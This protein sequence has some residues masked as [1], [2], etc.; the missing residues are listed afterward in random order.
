MNA[1]SAAAAPAPSLAGPDV[2]LLLKRSLDRI[3]DVPDYRER[4]SE[5]LAL[6]DHVRPQVADAAVGQVLDMA[7]IGVDH[8]STV[9]NALQVGRL[10]E[11]AI[12]S[13]QFGTF[14]QAAALTRDIIDVLRYD[15]KEHTARSLIDR[16]AARCDDPTAQRA[17]DLCACIASLCSWN[18][19]EGASKAALHTLASV[20]DGFDGSAQQTVELGIQL[21]RDVT[22]GSFD[23]SDLRPV[24]LSLCTGTDA[25]R[26]AAY[27]FLG[28]LIEPMDGESA[29]LFLRTE[30]D[31]VP[32]AL[33]SGDERETL[34]LAKTAVDVL[35]DSKRLPKDSGLLLESIGKVFEKRSHKSAFALARSLHDALCKDSDANNPD[36]SGLLSVALE[37]ANSN[38]SASSDREVL[39]AAGNLLRGMGS[40]WSGYEE[41][42]LGWLQASLDDKKTK[43]AVS[44]V[45]QIAQTV[46][47][48]SPVWKALDLATRALDGQPLDTLAWGREICATLPPAC[49][50]SG[51]LQLF[52]ML[53]NDP[54]R[55]GQA[56]LI[57]LALS[58]FGTFGPK[59][60]PT[61]LANVALTEIAAGKKDADL[62][63]LDVMQQMWNALP[64]A[65]ERKRLIEASAPTLVKLTDHPE[66]A[67]FLSLTLELTR[68]T[69]PNQTTRL[70]ESCLEKAKAIRD[71]QPFHLV[72]DAREVIN[73][74]PDRLFQASAL[75]RLVQ[76]VAHQQIAQGVFS[77]ALAAPLEVVSC[78]P[79]TSTGRMQR[80]LDLV[81]MLLACARDGRGTW[82]TLAKLYESTPV[83]ERDIMA[84]S[85]FRDLSPDDTSR[86]LDRFRHQALASQH[87]QALAST[88][89]SA[90]THTNLGSLVRDALENFQ[91]HEIMDSRA[92]IGATSFVLLQE[93]ER[94]VGRQPEV[95]AVLED[96]RHA[97]QTSERFDYEIIETAL[98]DAVRGVLRQAASTD[99]PT[100]KTVQAQALLIQMQHRWRDGA[101]VA[102]RAT[103][104]QTLDDLEQIAQGEDL[105]LEEWLL[106]CA[107][108]RPTPKVTEE[109]D[110]V[111]VGGVLIPKRPRQ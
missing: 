57:D 71:G 39:E 58:A 20:A 13:G 82:D 37:T 4:Q 100:L 27:R 10:A 70:F 29:A 102:N 33:A 60:E 92:Y 11:Q 75:R 89:Q 104:L 78:M 19:S 61:R 67:R 7:K 106:R 1:A 23:G 34:R 28:D 109:G 81:N 69:D 55:S 12:A 84:V 110:H 66:T 9:Y 46:K 88:I 31:L 35:R 80:N 94:R 72:D 101:L 62:D 38:K 91:R 49:A 22:G 51:Y 76:E 21:Q 50:A 95:E 64:S 26:D 105:T 93:I 98:H 2:A 32:A 30:I 16:L 45:A 24:V 18:V 41:Q 87:W 79:E 52:T 14:P 3:E 5:V 97:T 8:K 56:R 48:P 96:L 54:A 103:L 77:G 42:V 44:F 73:A 99:N 65:E 83:T 90:Q 59:E 15:P 43:A 36:T 40:A 63:P 17:V 108:E 111:I 68:G 47:A 6:L 53:K 25:N 85:V 86:N 107:D 74:V